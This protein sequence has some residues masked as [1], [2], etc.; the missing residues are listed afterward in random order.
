[1]KKITVLGLGLLFLVSN[2]NALDVGVGV[3]VGTAGAGLNLSAAVTQNVNV[4]LSL[5]SVDF[6]EEDETIDVG[7]SGEGELDAEVDLDFGANAVLIDWY[8]FKGGFHLTAGMMR[9]TGE[10]D[11]D[12]TLTSG[13]S[14]NGV[15]ITPADISNISGE[16]E[17]ADS[18]QPYIGIGWGRK[19]GKNGGFSLTA[20]LGIALLDPSV[21]LDATTTGL[22]V[23]QAEIDASLREMEK[24]AEDELDDFEAWPVLSV[25]LNYAF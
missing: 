14:F 9:H 1:M 7:D 25:G 5:T 18:Y 11:F 10:A 17:F 3:K 2:A 23:T 4:R 16:V 13:A 15:D 6:D 20:D 24:D 8:I 19:A 22:G 12:G 21:K